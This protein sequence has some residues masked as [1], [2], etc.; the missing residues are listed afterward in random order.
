MKAS[1]KARIKKLSPQNPAPTNF[2]WQN[3][4]RGAGWSDIRGESLQAQS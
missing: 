4:A 2:C 3:W 1:T